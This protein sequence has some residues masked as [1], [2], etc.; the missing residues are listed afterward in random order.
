[1]R[2]W[3]RALERD[4]SR[5]AERHGEVAVRAFL[6]YLW[7]S[8]HFLETRRTQAYHLVAGQGGQHR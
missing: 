8:H 7:S 1:V 5:L 4:R 6:L 2:D 3:A